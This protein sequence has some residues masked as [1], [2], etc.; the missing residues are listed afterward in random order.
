MMKKMSKSKGLVVLLVTIV[1]IVALSLV[2]AYG[3]GEKKVG[4]AENIKLGLDLAGGVSITYQVVSDNPTEEQMNDTVYKLAKRVEVYSTEAQ[5]YKEG[6]DRINV[7]IPGVTDAN[8]ILQELGK[9]GS[10]EFQTS[11]GTVVLDGTGVEAANAGTQTNSVGNKE[12]VVELKLTEDGKKA[13][14]EATANNIGKTLPIVFDGEVI[15]NPTV[16]T[17]ITDGNA[18]ITGMD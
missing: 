18:I 11:D 13:F 8:A 5:V 17:A 4:A 2:S 12:F 6:D 9:P 10:L 1:C 7:E 3:V 16:N 14:A 15:C